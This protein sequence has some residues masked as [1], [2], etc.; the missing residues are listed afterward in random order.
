[1]HTNHFQTIQDSYHKLCDFCDQIWNRVHKSYSQEIACRKGCDICCELQ[2]VNQLEA[3]II[4]LYLQKK[5]S[6]F[7][8]NQDTEYNSKCPFLR[9][10]VCLIYEA[11]PLICRTHG[12]VLRSNEFVNSHASSCPY[13]FPSLRPDEF[14]AELTLDTDKITKNLMNLNLAFCMCKNIHDQA[15]NR[16]QLTDLYN[17]SAF[18]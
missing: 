13:N 16:V 14:S 8:K 1:M 2:S 5:D 11:R 9:E 10:Q 7:I 18:M 6:F 12:L 15:Q 3:Y 4:R 17:M